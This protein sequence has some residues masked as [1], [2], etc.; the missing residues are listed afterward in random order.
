MSNCFGQGHMYS[1]VAGPWRNGLCFGISSSEVVSTTV[2]Y[3]C[4]RVVLDLDSRGSRLKRSAIS[5]TSI[6]SA[7]QQLVFRAGRRPWFPASRHRAACVQDT[8]F[9]FFAAACSSDLFSSLEYSVKLHQT[10]NRAE[11]KRNAQ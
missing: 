1:L 7:V 3:G 2:R 10:L 5:C 6:A 4:G 11:P 8:T 9:F